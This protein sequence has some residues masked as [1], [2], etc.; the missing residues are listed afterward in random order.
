MVMLQTIQAVS[1]ELPEFSALFHSYIVSCW[2]LSSFAGTVAGIYWYRPKNK[3]QLGDSCDVA[4][5]TNGV[6]L[7][8]VQQYL[9]F[10]E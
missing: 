7:A 3:P 10:I 5:P 1:T 9:Y 8:G 2:I 6:Y 4:S